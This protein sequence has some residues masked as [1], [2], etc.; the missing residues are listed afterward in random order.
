MD[1]KTGPG[2]GAKARYLAKG[3]FFGFSCFYLIFVIIVA[4]PKAFPKIFDDKCKKPIL[5]KLCNMT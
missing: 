1:F 4:M 3:F 2:Y 5:L